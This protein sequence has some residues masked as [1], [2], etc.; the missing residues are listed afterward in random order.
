MSRGR[1]G[2]FAHGSLHDPLVPY[3]HFVRLYTLRAIETPPEPVGWFAGEPVMWLALRV[4]I[5]TLHY[6]F[7]PLSCGML[8]EAYA[9]DPREGADVVRAMVLPRLHTLL[10]AENPFAVL[11]L[12]A[13]REAQ[14][15]R[16]AEIR[17]LPAA[18]APLPGITPP[19]V[20]RQLPARSQTSAR[21]ARIQQALEVVQTAAE[22][23]Q[24]L[25]AAWQNWQIGRERVKLLGA[26]RALL[27]DAIQAQMAGQARALDD[28]QDPGFV[29]GYL[30]AHGSD[31][32][33]D[34]VFDAS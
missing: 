22:T 10:E 7:A 27:Q 19:P 15:Q 12:D 29:R 5:E 25:A 18:R 8:D 21:L 31:E 28:G 4:R 9:A 23:A 3:G 16:Y 34:A 32:A 33:I 13:D 30:A 2:R 24:T 17:G 1:T 6:S 14:W 26:Q 20:R 11:G